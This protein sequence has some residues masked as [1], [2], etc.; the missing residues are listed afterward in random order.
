MNEQKS[1]ADRIKTADDNL[2][3]TQTNTNDAA[4]NPGG[5]TEP[6]TSLQTSHRPH[7]SSDIPQIHLP[8]M[9]NRHS[10]ADRPKTADDYQE[11][12][13]A[14]NLDRDRTTLRGWTGSSSK[15]ST[16][17]PPPAEPP[18]ASASQ[19]KEKSRGRREGKQGQEETAEAMPDGSKP[20]SLKKAKTARG[21]T[22]NGIAGSETTPRPPPSHL[23]T[24]SRMETT[25]FPP[26]QPRTGADA[27]G[28]PRDKARRP[29]TVGR[30]GTRRTRHHAR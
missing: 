17:P 4:S 26:G 2:E 28:R 3:T 11:N 23:L 12:D 7:Y 15:N 22:S 10:S 19:L 24:H 20:M 8:P 29:A 16:K 1:P 14:I 6:P 21:S 27:N 25:L 13:D 5:P 18:P 9:N 30:R